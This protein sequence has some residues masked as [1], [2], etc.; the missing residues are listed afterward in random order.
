VNSQLGKKLRPKF[1]KSLRD[2]LP[3]FI[4]VKEADIPSGDRLFAWKLSERLTIFVL[5][6]MH[7]SEEWFN[8]SVGWSEH[9]KWPRIPRQMSPSDPPQDGEMRFRLRRLWETKPRGGWWELAPRVPLELMASYALNPPPLDE[10]LAKVDPL[11]EDAIGHLQ[12]E[13]MDYFRQV[14]TE[15]GITL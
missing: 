7:R 1:T 10:P 11:V 5:L 8:L 14:A 3:S 2:A 9:G 15:H 12:K 13:G 4:E 6:E